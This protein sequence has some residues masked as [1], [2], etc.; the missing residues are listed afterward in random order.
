MMP[1][2]LFLVKFVKVEIRQPYFD[3]HPEKSTTDNHAWRVGL[4]VH[5][6]DQKGNQLIWMPKWSEI[7]EILKGKVDVEQQNKDLCKKNLADF[8]GGPE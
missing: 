4:F 8:M 3:P 2:N 6:T 1:E 5:L 7:E